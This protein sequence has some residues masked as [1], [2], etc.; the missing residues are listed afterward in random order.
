MNMLKDKGN[1]VN[2]YVHIRSNDGNNRTYSGEVGLDQI[3][4][5]SDCD[6]NCDG[7]TGLEEAFHSLQITAGIKN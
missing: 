2:F 7:K 4:G 1:I 5:F 3:P 6:V